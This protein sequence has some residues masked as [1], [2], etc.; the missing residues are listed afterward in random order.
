MG[1]GGGVGAGE[2]AE[3]VLAL[4][5]LLGEEG[6]VNVACGHA[7]CEAGARVGGWGGG[8]RI[9]EPEVE[10]VDGAGRCAGEGLVL[11]RCVF[12]EHRGQEYGIGQKWEAVLSQGNCDF[13][14]IIS[15]FDEV[16]L[17]APHEGIIER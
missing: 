4:Q 17:I 2:E 8:V 10:D 12:N 11:Q 14:V 16:I 13:C 9:V 7:D 5:G 1:G 3:G 6:V 15:N